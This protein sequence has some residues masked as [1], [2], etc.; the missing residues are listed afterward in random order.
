MVDP[1][2]GA[3]EDA[4]RKRATPRALQP[5]QGRRALTAPPPLP[6]APRSESPL[7][8]RGPRAKKVAKSG[9]GTQDAGGLLQAT[10]WERKKLLELMHEDDVFAVRFSI[11]L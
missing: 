4:S 8:P 10:E 6:V 2:S 5:G 1:T 11:L 7:S 9:L 3:A